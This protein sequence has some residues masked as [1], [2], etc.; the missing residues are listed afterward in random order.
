[1]S[2]STFKAATGNI[3]PTCAG[4]SLK[5]Q[6]Y[7]EILETLPDIG[8]FEV[9]AE[10]YMSAGGPSHHALTRIRADYPL[11][12]H[13]VGLSIGGAGP[14][15]E[16]HL[17]RLKTVVDRYQPGLVSEHLAW[18]SHGG[19]YYPDLLP[20]PYTS[21][22][23]NTVAQHI[24]QIQDVLGR[25]ILLENPAT[26][27]VFETSSLQEVDFLAEV[28]RRTG[29]GLLL[30]INN[31]Y[32]SA[33]N[34]GYDP[35]AY[36]ADF[37][38]KSVGEIHLAGHAEDQ[39]DAGAPLLIDSH[40]RPVS[41]PV[42]DLYDHVLSLIGPVPSLIEWDSDIP[43]LNALMAQASLAEQRLAQAR[44]GAYATSV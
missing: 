2:P 14:L 25:P 30:D 3:I 26:Y 8:W 38:L 4:T 11:S 19:L 37:P 31:V 21:E 39:D 17:A 24:D 20:L 44:E 10:N 28:T 18:S 41:P 6:H 35:F 27:I 42:W 5:P 23:L 36:L 7:D 9:H 22:T 1:M 16:T 15:D 34:H 33:T 32:V 40:D 29:C 12:V 13:S 43:A